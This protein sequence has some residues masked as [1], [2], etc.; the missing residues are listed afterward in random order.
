MFKVRSA[1]C[2]FKDDFKK[3][4]RDL[5]VLVVGDGDGQGALLGE[6]HVERG[7][8]AFCR[9]QSDNSNSFSAS[10]PDP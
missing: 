5:N 3:A 10:L 6:I 1:L 8:Q 4:R 9:L 2:I 7:Y